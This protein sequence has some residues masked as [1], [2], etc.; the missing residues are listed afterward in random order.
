MTDKKLKLLIVDD[1][2]D[3]CTFVKLLFR[4]EGFLTYS[5]LSGTQAVRLA[6][7][8]KPDIALLDIRLK[9]GISGLDVLRGIRKSVPACRCVMVTWDKGEERIKEARLIGAIDYLTKPLTTVQLLK[10]VNRISK[11]IGSAAK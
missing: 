10:V 9:R 8:I 2:K 4:K 11:S 1:E 5:A 3:I 7:K 6:K